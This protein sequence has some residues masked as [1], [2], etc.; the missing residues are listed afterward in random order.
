MSIKVAFLVK[1]KFQIAQFHNLASSYPGA[2]YLLVNRRS[3]KDEFTAEDFR[4]SGS[5]I[6]LVNQRSVPSVAAEFD[7]VFF[8]TVFPSIQDV[9]VPLVSLQYGLAKERHNYGEW[10]SLADLNLMYGRYSSEIVSHFSPGYAVGNAKFATWR[11]RQFLTAENKAEAKRLIG[12]DPN[13]PV[14]LYMPTYGELG[15]FDQL[16]KPLAGLTRDIQVAIK[17]HHNNELTGKK[18]VENARKIGH[19]HLFHGDEDQTKLLAA[20]DVVVSDFSGAI[21]DGIYAELPVVLFQPKVDEKVGIQKFDL[22]SLEFR[23]RHELGLVVEHADDIGTAIKSAYEDRDSVVERA[24]A[25]RDELFVDASTTDVI[26]N[27]NSLVDDMLAGRLPRLTDQQLHVRQGVK[28]LL[29]A[30]QKLHRAEVGARIWRKLRGLLAR[31]Q[32]EPVG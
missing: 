23:R 3:L 11:H 9:T 18:W 27:M 30:E 1:N 21:F 8:Q 7:V 16:A 29:S 4:R 15:S 26:A 6:R 31:R 25:I 24:A 14:A 20:A 2:V 32:G 19:G 5:A 12:L 10:R 17:I 28:R 13:R 22:S